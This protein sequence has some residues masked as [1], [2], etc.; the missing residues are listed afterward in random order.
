M[1]YVLGDSFS[2]GTELA[3]H[4]IPSWPGHKSTRVDH[5][6]YQKWITDPA[7]Q[8]EIDDIEDRAGLEMFDKIQKTLSWPGQLSE[9]TGIKVINQSFA[10]SGPSYWPYRLAQDLQYYSPHTVI[11]QFTSIDRE[12]LF[13]SSPPNQ[14]HPKFVTASLVPKSGPET[15]YFVN[16]K[17]IED[18]AA[19]FYKFLV[20]VAISQAICRS[21]GIKNIH[22]V[23]TFN[24]ANTTLLSAGGHDK[25]MQCLDIVKAWNA[26]GIDWLMLDSIQSCSSHPIL[27]PLYMVG[28]MPNGHHNAATY[29]RFAEIIADKY[30]VNT[31]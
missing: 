23:S 25:L 4:L 13:T 22:V 5:V 26:T 21:H 15:D 18:S 24:F 6:A 28:E 31:P 1:I 14:I 9:I 27:P 12:V 17:L 7:T 19:N 11:L 2:S 8:Q 3:D 20:T 29:R 30:I 16:L 10:S